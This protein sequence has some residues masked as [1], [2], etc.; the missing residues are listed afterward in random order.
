[1]PPRL[2]PFALCAAAALA[3]EMKRVPLITNVTTTAALDRPE[4]RLRPRTDRAAE[5]GVSTD[6]LAEAIRVA[7]LGDIDANL[8]KFN[9]GDRL[10]PIGRAD[11]ASRLRTARAR[12]EDP[13][14][15][16]VIVSFL[17]Q[18]RA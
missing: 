8:A 11:F 10:V 5:L 6:A 14:R 13:S 18:L 1:M 16:A 12:T 3:S 17:K 15:R 7:T 4:I 9:A 2:R